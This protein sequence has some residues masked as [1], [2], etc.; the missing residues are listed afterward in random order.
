MDGQGLTTHRVTGLAGVHGTEAGHADRDR[1]RRV[2]GSSV[3]D[4]SEELI[5]P[6]LAR[7]P[8]WE[9]R[10]SPEKNG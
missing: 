6:H 10:R 9:R 8:G 3:D 2:P 1:R 7:R 4:P 5:R